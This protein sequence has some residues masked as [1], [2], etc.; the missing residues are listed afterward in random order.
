MALDPMKQFDVK[1]LIPLE[2]AGLDVSITNQSL[3]M[4]IAIS[5][6]TLLMY[7]GARGGRTVPG[8]LQSFVELTYGF[9]EGMVKDTTGKHGLPYV[10][11]MLTLFLFIASL[12]LFGMI[13]GSYTST[14]MIQISGLMA[15]TVFVGV[16][17]I[18]F[19]K[20]GL[21]FFNIFYP[22]GTPIW[23]APLIVPLEMISFF[24]RPFTL[25]VRL[26]ANMFAGHILL[27]VF[28]GFCVMLASGVAFYVA[29]PGIVLSVLVALAITA[30]EVFVALLQAYIFT[31]LAC[32]YLNDALHGH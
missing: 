6:I 9:I 11:Y 2:V 4:I 18:G 13:P 8:R 29:V 31:I 16:I 15:L 12:N 30:L 3:W 14:S 23:L 22:A 24:A 17:V 7:A 19:I 1:P 32:V 28:A 27:K 26:T 5:C 25:A 10:P 21:G 20:Q